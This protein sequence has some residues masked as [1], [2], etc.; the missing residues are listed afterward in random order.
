[1]NSKAAYIIHRLQIFL[2]LQTQM[3]FYLGV[4]GCKITTEGCLTPTML[5]LYTTYCSWGCKEKN[6]YF[7]LSH[8]LSLSF[9]N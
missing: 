5:V 9:D 7:I 4:L 1:M 8:S 6:I 2:S 3:K